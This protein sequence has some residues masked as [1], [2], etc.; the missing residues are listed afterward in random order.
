MKQILIL[1]V[2]AAVLLAGCG[3]DNP[4]GDV[5]DDEDDA[6]AFDC[7]ACPTCDVCESCPVCEGGSVGECVFAG[8]PVDLV[9]GDVELLQE[10][11]GSEEG[12]NYRY[13]RDEYNNLEKAVLKFT[14]DCSGI[15]PAVEIEVDDEIVWNQV[16]DCGEVHEVPIFTSLLDE[17][18]HTIYFISDVDDD[19]VIDDITLVSTFEDDTTKEEDLFM[20]EF[21]PGTDDDEEFKNLNN[22][23]ITNYVEYE[24]ELD[25]DEADQD[26]VLSFR[27]EDRDGDLVVL[28]NDE[29]IYEGSVKKRENRITIPA[30]KLKDGR[31]YL[32]FVGVSE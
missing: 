7:P 5:T 23:V 30:A 15:V 14:P 18:R 13:T 28:I 16:P 10:G 31:N 22:V 21:E 9:L 8:D 19:Y 11:R 27:G 17:G 32:T 20:I 26:L 25:D 1:I 12:V 4:T 29:Q 2:C 24:I 3:S 6:F